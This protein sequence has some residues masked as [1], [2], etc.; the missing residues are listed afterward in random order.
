MFWVMSG[1]ME[2]AVVSHDC[3]ESAFFH[4]TTTRVVGLHGGE[5]RFLD[6]PEPSE[7]QVGY[8]QGCSG[9]SHWP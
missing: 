4:G 3:L 5:P 2:S 1:S 6:G 7:A 9:G 8:G